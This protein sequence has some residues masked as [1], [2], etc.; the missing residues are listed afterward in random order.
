MLP[1]RAQALDLV[2]RH[3]DRPGEFA[4]LAFE[5]SSAPDHKHRD[6]HPPTMP[7]TRSTGL[8][9]NLII[10]FSPPAG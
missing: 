4:G 1:F 2:A 8:N 10:V 6:R 7:A 9:N 5:P 3:P